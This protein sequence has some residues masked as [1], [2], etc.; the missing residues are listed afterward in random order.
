MLIDPSTSLWHLNQ[1]FQIDFV[2]CHSRYAVIYLYQTT[3]LTYLTRCLS[4]WYVVPCLYLYCTFVSATF[5]QF[6]TEF[7][8]FEILFH[9]VYMWEHTKFLR[10]IWLYASKGYQYYGKSGQD[11]NTKLFW[12]SVVWKFDIWDSSLVVFRVTS[13]CELTSLMLTR[14]SLKFGSRS[15]FL[16]SSLL[17][18][19]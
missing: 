4:E 14:I 11:T 13:P 1:L 8:G 10:V 16:L 2:Y 5:K 7:A 17:Q 12:K 19:S 15:Y 6:L 18:I 3:C 9:V